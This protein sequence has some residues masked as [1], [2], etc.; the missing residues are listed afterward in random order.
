MHVH[1]VYSQMSARLVAPCQHEREVYIT[2]AVP[3]LQKDNATGILSC[4]ELSFF[5]MRTA[6]APTLADAL[7]YQNHLRDT[8]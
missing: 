6:P 3:D 5:P 7:A 2:K 4:T 8:G 1:E